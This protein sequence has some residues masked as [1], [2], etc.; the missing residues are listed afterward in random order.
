MVHV[1]RENG[2]AVLLAA[3][4]VL[5]V[6]GEDGHGRLIPDELE[7]GG[8]RGGG[9]GGP[10]LGLGLGPGP[11]RPK[12]LAAQHQRARRR[13]VCPRLGRRRRLGALRCDWGGRDG[14]G[15]D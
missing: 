7:L 1:F 12:A 6:V 14:S 2:G 11:P 15:R 9:A 3:V 10:G 4:L 8:S 5:V 13:H